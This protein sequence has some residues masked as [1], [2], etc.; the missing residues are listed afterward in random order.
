[1]EI[2]DFVMAAS[3]GGSSDPIMSWEVVARHLVAAGI[4]FAALL[5][6]AFLR[7]WVKTTVEYKK[8][9]NNRYGKHYR[10][11]LDVMEGRNTTWYYAETDK[12]WSYWRWIFFAIVFS[13]FYKRSNLRLKHSE[14]VGDAD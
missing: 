11:C 4:P 1:M 10:P 6:I 3:N 8:Y 9:L 14:D 12:R 13:I 5:V 2:Y 7:L